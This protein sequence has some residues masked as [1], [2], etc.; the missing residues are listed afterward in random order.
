[1][2]AMVTNSMLF[3]P[4]GEIYPPAIKPLVEELTADLLLSALSVVKPPKSCE[5]PVVAMV[6]KSMLLNNDG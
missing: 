6:I 4:V 2:V 3:V 5:L 1:M